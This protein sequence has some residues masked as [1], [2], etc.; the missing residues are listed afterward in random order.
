MSLSFVIGVAY[1][2]LRMIEFLVEIFNFM[3]NF[4]FVVVDD[5]NNNIVT[6]S[7]YA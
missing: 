3:D 7:I 1:G 2:I 5:I 6:T 4:L